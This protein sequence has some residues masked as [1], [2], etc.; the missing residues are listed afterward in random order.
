M[1]MAAEWT[2]NQT[3]SL[4]IISVCLIYLIYCA[5]AAKRN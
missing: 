3:G 5:F 2:G 4:A 1:G